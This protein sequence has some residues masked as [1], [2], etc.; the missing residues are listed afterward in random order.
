MT[1]YGGDATADAVGLELMKIHQYF[2]V[3]AEYANCT[4][5]GTRN[6][7]LNKT[8]DQY[9]YMRININDIPQESIGEYKLY[10]LN[11]VNN[12]FVFVKI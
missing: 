7:Y 9:I 11:L 8:L 10:E 3:S 6:F 4:M 12:G 2:A 1:R 5:M